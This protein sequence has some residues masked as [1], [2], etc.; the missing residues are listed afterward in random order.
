MPKNHKAED[1]TVQIKCSILGYLNVYLEKPISVLYP[2]VELALFSAHYQPNPL[3][4]GCGKATAL[5]E[6]TRSANA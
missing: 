2:H 1:P 6:I 4:I 3:L 5:G